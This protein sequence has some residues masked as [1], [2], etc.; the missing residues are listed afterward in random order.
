M[1]HLALPGATPRGAALLRPHLTRSIWRAALIE[2]ARVGYD[3]M[4]MDA[5]ARRAGVGKAAVYRRWSSKEAMIVAMITSI[6]LEIVQAED[7]GNLLDDVGAYVKAGLKLIR[8]P[9]A[10][11]ILP[12][13][14]SEMSRN[15]ALAAAIRA[16][17][18]A[19]KKESVGQLLQRA[20]AR[21]ELAR[22]IDADMA[23]D[24]IVGPIY[25]RALISRAVPGEEE[26]RLLARSITAALQALP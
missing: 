8:R 3:Q 15:S 1:E 2:L 17:V 20:V 24:L 6:D 13:F 18:Y 10:S 4:S 16:T 25:W 21:G 23:F 5:V 26:T 7:R 22:D 19:R 9:L 14:Y 11:R 12:D